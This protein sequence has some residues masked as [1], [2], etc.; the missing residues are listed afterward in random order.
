MPSSRRILLVVLSLAALTMLGVDVAAVAV[1]HPKRS[2]A[3]SNIEP[4]TTEPAPSTSAAPATTAAAPATTATAP[5][6]T[7]ATTPTP[8]T[9]TASTTAPATGTG[10]TSKGSGQVAGAQPAVGTTGGP[11]LLGAGLMLLILAGLVRGLA[12]RT[13]ATR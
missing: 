5:A 8:P 4:A 11:D 1:H 13:A 2:H 3:A 7:S 12:R 6:T 9:S 10:L